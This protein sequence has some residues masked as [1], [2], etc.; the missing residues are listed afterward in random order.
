MAALAFLRETS[1]SGAFNLG[2][3]SGFSVLDVI[4]AVEKVTGRSLKLIDAPRREGDPARLIGDASLAQRVLGW[5][6]HFTDIE[7]IVRHAWRWET[8]MASS[9]S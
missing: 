5:T 4:D 8:K 6:P 9:T 1:R 7:T 3:G 2:N